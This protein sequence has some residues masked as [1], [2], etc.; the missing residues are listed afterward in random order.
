[1]SERRAVMGDPSGVRVGG[2]VEAFAPGFGA[3]LGRL[4]YAPNTV[5]LQLQLVA[6]L[7]GWLA[8][9]GLDGTALTASAAGRFLSFRRAA[10]YTHYLSPKALVPLLGY[11]RGLGVAPDAPAAD[12]GAGAEALLERYLRYLLGERGLTPAGASRYLS[13]VRPFLA[14]RP[15]GAGGLST[16]DVTGFVVGQCQILAPKGAQRMTSALRSFLRFLA[17]EGLADASLAAAVPAVADWRLSGLPKALEP[18]QVDGLLASCDRATAAGRR[19]FAMLVLLA[20]LGLRAGE[21][22]G[23]RLDDLDW[24]RGEI[25]VRGKGGRSDRLPLPADAGEALA[26]YLT[27]GRPGDAAGREGFMRVKAPHRALTAGGGTPAVANPRPPARPGTG[28]AHPVRP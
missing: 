17:V 2:A 14:G 20:R 8:G 5:C 4:G 12:P 10:G 24:R 7:S 22:A 19:D 13:S 28:H 6:H 11:L 15:D 16:A 9:E 21:V 3:E 27:A 18:A 25:V 1:M 23:L 26:G